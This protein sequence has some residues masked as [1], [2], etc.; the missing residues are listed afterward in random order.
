MKK[1]L[2]SL[3]VLGVLFIASSCTDPAADE[4]YD[5]KKADAATATVGDKS[6]DTD[7]NPPPAP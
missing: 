4:L 7:D 5:L 2:T 3:F 6:P 1:T